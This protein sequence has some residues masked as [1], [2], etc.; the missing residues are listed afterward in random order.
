MAVYTYQAFDARQ[1]GCSGTVTADTVAL[2]RQA[3]RDRGLV[4]AGI[5]EFRTASG[6]SWRWLQGGVGS[7]RGARAEAVAELWRNLAVLLRAGVA[8]TD[9]LEVCRR[10]Q[11]GPLPGVVQQIIE[12][13]RT[14]RSLAEALAVHG[15]WFDEL[16]RSVVQVGERSGTLAEALG[17]LADYQARRRAVV[18]RLSSALIYPAILCLVGAAVVV[19]LMGHIVP[20]LLDVLASAGRELPG[21]TR[22]LKAVSDALVR[23]WPLLLT[24][25]LGLAAGLTALRRTERGRRG[26]ERAVLAI[27]VLGDLLKKS[28]IARIS[29]MLAT[30]LRSDVRFTEALRTVRRGLPHRLYADELA[31]LEQAIEAGAGIADPLRDSRLIPPLV[32]HLLAVGQESGELPR[33]LDEVRSSCEQHVQLALTRFLAVLEPALILVLAAVIGLV[34]FATLLPILETTR[35][36]Q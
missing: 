12:H 3:L 15:D 7:R 13:L 35:I 27:P 21:P 16:T 17:E 6:A 8:L 4:V 22:G 20:Q 1:R 10:Q 30:M 5:G 26:L 19:F 28:W 25:G 2:A 14:G 34:V 11:R 9:A 29:L 24:A 31:A 32:T 23:S 36:V 18:N 33:M